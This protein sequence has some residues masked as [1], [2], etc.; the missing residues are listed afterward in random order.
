MAITETMAVAFTI[1]MTWFPVGGMMERMAWGR[2]TRKRI[3]RL[4]MPKASAVSRCAGSTDWRPA[5]MIS[6]M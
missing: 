4:L 5:R 3:W 6:P 1:E 2:S